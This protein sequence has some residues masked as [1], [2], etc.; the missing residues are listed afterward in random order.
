MVVK[1]PFK[2]EADFIVGLN[3]MRDIQPQKFVTKMYKF[4]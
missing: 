2:V 1:S 3:N 4:K